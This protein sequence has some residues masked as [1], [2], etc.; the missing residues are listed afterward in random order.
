[1]PAST[2][3]KTSVALPSALATPMSASMTR[4]SS[5]PDAIS[6]SGP[7]GAPAFGAMRNS[8]ASAPD[9]PRSRAPS[10]TPKLPP[11]IPRAAHPP[12]PAPPHPRRA[13]PPPAQG[14]PR[15]GPRPG[16]SGRQLGRP[17]LELRLR[18]RELRRRPVERHLG[19]GQL[20]AP[21]A[22]ALGMG[23]HRGDRAAVLALQALE[24]G[25][26]LLG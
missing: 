21:R 24:H 16:P 19:P 12:P 26:A 9:G 20:V 8:T 14:R 15:P 25:Q 1:M 13:P 6:R 3:S 2:S 11:P 18:R 7:A 4:D 23:Q 17:L 22:A 10:A 5:P